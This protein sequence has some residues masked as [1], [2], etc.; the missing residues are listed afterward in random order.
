MKLVGFGFHRRIRRVDYGSD[1]QKDAPMADIKDPEN[2]IIIE[3]KDGNVMIELLPDVA[4]K[5]VERMKQLARDGA[6]DNVAGVCDVTVLDGNVNIDP[7]KRD[8][9][10]QIQIVQRFPSH[11]NSPQCARRSP[12]GGDVLLV[13]NL[14]CRAGRVNG[15]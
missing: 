6:Y 15:P 1:L 10:V 7:D 8:L 9:A 11:V 5:H 3:L 14:Q 4:P 12:G 2:T 13:R